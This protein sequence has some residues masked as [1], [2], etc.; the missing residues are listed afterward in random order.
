[1]G[2]NPRVL[3]KMRQAGDRG[4]V[5]WGSDI[6]SKWFVMP[7]KECVVSCQKEAQLCFL[8]MSFQHSLPCL[9][10]LSLCPVPCWAVIFH[11]W[12]CGVT[13]ISPSRALC[14]FIWTQIGLKPH[15][16]CTLC[17]P[18]DLVWDPW[19]ENWTPFKGWVCGNQIIVEKSVFVLDLWSSGL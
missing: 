14:P 16:F 12:L 17:L 1:M 2:L 5:H 19:H 13:S 18:G 4:L 9:Q 10:H 6:P 15:Y 3:E 7:L 11:P 8:V